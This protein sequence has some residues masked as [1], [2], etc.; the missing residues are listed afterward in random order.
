MRTVEEHFTI[1]DAAER[2]H[3]STDTIERWIKRGIATNGREGIWPVTKPG[4]CVLI[5]A[6]SLQRLLNAGKLTL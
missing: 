4:K 5:P 6:S 1:S 2:I 3:Q